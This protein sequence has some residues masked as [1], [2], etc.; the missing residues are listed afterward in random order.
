M[1]LPPVINSEGAVRCKRDG[2]LR[3]ESPPKVSHLAMSNLSQPFGS[4]KVRA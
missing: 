3:L 2:A 1:G 4:Q